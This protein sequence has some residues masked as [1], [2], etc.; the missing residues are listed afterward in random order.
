M[1]DCT[2]DID[3]R[4]PAGRILD[5]YRSGESWWTI[6]NIL[7]GERGAPCRACVREHVHD[8]I[9]GSQNAHVS[10]MQF[11]TKLWAA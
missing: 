2:V 11:V 10:W 5:L 3:V 8:V 6:T 4:L 7:S 1:T 9:T